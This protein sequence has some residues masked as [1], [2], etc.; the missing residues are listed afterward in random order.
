M[1]IC[2]R[3]SKPRAATERRAA[4]PGIGGEP[5]SRARST[6]VRNHIGPV[7][8]RCSEA[9]CGRRRRRA[10][11]STS[12]TLLGFAA[13]SRPLASPRSQVV[14]H[15]ITPGN[16]SSTREFEEME[17]EFF[18]PPAEAEGWYRTWIEERERWYTELGIRPEFLRVRPHTPTIS[19]TTP[20]ATSD[21]EY[22]FPIGWSE[23]GGHR[24]PR[25]TSTSPSTP[26]SAARRSS[27]FDQGTKS[28]TSPT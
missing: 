5:R 8:A 13:R 23:V 18:V 24:Q 26:S 4:L 6:D 22:L 11:S 20:P 27:Y 19:P 1:T 14:P 15:E 21:V 28:A 10:S 3:R 7:A 17:M 16:S 9:T 12:R 2:A 25:R